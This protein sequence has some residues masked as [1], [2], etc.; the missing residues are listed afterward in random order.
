MNFK[1]TLAGPPRRIRTHI[2]GA[3]WPTTERIIVAPAK[4]SLWRALLA[5][6]RRFGHRSSVRGH[7]ASWTH[8]QKMCCANSERPQGGLSFRM[9]TWAISQHR[10]RLKPAGW[11]VS[12]SPTRQQ[13]D[14]KGSFP[15]AG[16]CQN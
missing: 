2:R 11:G 1:G 4:G 15:L 5:T 14:Q 13:T 8:R 3:D 12:P 16:K 6:G 9:Y 10:D 7:H